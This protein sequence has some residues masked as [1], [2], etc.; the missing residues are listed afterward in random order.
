MLIIWFVSVCV[1]LLNCWRWICVGFVCWV[2]MKIII[3]MW[4]FRVGCNGVGVV[5]DSCFV[6]VLLV[7]YVVS[8]VVLVIVSIRDCC[9][10]LGRVWFFRLVWGG[11]LIGFVLVCLMIIISSCI[12]ILICWV[13]CR[14]VV[15]M[16]VKIVV[17]KFGLVVWWL[18]WVG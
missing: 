7:S 2:W 6:I 15:L 11:C 5:V 14:F 16:C 10:N 12:L 18:L 9:C 8:W 1:M 17:E 4:V 13:G 3:F